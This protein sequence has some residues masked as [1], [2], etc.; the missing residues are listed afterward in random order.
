MAENKTRPTD[1]N[2]GAHISAIA[3][4]ARRRDCEQLVKL[5]ANITKQPPRLWG[6]SIVGF[7]SYHYEYA[8]GREGDMCV[9]GFASRKGAISIYLLA[10]GVKQAQLLE[11]LGKHKMGKACLNVKRLADIDTDVLQQLVAGSV[12]QVKRRYG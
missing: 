10:S 12:A 5:M 9:T 6:S 11:K 7:G 1:A 4:E 8:S 2:V 3:D